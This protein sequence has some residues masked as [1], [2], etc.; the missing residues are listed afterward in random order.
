MLETI[1][2]HQQSWL[3]YVIFI[4]IIVVFAVNFGPGSS[5]CQSG[6]VGTSY[7]AMVDGD[8][9]RLQDF[10][11]AYSQQFEAMRRRA[12]ASNFDMNEKLAEQ[13]GLRQSVIDQLI[14]EK[15]IGKEAERRGI[16]V[17]DAELLEHLQ[18]LYRVK[19]ATEE[20]YRNFVERNF[21]T[22]RQRFEDDQRAQLAA[23]KLAGV[24]TDNLGISDKELL[25]DFLRDRD[26]A[27]IEYVKFDLGS[28]KLVEPT[29][30]AI[31]ELI[32]K[33]AKAIEDRFQAD[34]AR[35][36]T[37]EKRQARMIL[38]SLGKD[39]TDADVARARSTLETLRD[40]VG[41]GA[42]FAALAKEKSQ[43]AAT[44]ALGGDLGLRARGELPAGLDAVIFSLKPG[45][46]AKE[47][48]R[49]DTGMALVKL[50][51]VKASEPRPL[52]EVRRDVAISIVR[53]RS[54]DA[55]LR[56][57]AEKLLAELKGGKKLADLTV[58]EEESDKGKADK[59]PVAKPVRFE[60]AWIVRTQEALPR[61]GVAPELQKDIFALTTQSPLAPKV[62]SINR[63]YYVVV[64]KDRELP[65]LTKFE[66]EKEQLRQQAL[67]T[68]R[69]RVFQD[70]VKSLRTRADVQLN[71]GLFG[72][73]APT[74]EG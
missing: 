48:V 30:A 74:D 5:S 46:V 40:Q 13:M 67:W 1:R 43:D 70:W 58:T 22:T 3:T 49:T 56:G 34:G 37:P 59:K 63:A 28:V 57:A 9:I 71:Q 12:L 38:L 6:G 7:A 47:P 42:D 39:A 61:I 36:R 18:K 68:K 66:A 45:D 21:H 24:V 41:T 52:A 8:Y 32:A 60:S 44:A 23:Q 54:A 53:E 14:N 50:E 11:L 73:R 29:A 10:Q 65:D 25:A 4:A 64:L 19:D 26:R 33:D 20:D 51:T 2:R 31:D 17:S 15:L 16:R 72:R 55:Q 62:Y 69:S 27:M 35:Y